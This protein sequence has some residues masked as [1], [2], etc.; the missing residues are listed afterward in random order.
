L[1]VQ[2]AIYAA[3]GTST[4]ASIRFYNANTGLYHPG[5]DALGIITSGT[6]KVRITSGGNVGIGTSSPGSKLDIAWGG[7]Q[8]SGYA[9]TFGADIG[10]LSTRTN[11]TIK[12]GIISGVP[13]VN[14]N[15][16]IELITY[17]SNST[18]NSISIGGSGNTDL[19]GVNII[20]FATAP[21]QTSPGVERMRITSGGATQIKGTLQTYAPASTTTLGPTYKL[22]QYI[23][24]TVSFATTGYIYV[25]ID[26]TGYYLAL[27]NPL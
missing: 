9:M 20:G 19:D 13:Y 12:Y 27:A 15:P 21:N 8:T 26:G 10:N 2:D 4:S 11:N 17:Y 25:E 3:D 23:A 18:E 6:E 16:N 24:T 22:G 7:Y 14:A 5:S 1:R